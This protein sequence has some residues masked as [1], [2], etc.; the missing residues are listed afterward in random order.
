MKDTLLLI[1][2]SFA[3]MS[4]GAIAVKASDDRQVPRL[5]GKG[6][7]GANGDL[8]AMEEDSFPT[9]C[10]SIQLWSESNERHD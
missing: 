6:C 9:S 7:L 3:L 8:F 10:Q 5:V 2:Y 4:V 1:G